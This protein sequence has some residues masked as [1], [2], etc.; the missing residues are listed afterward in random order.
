MHRESW[1]SYLFI[2]ID[3]R[4]GERQILTCCP[5]QGP[6]PQL[7]HTRMMLYPT[8]LPT[9]DLKVGQFRT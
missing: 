6:N 2:F 4:E 5:D 8:E 9:Q 7:W 1:S 3:L